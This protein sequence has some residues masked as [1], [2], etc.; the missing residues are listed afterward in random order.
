MAYYE[1]KAYWVVPRGLS[2][3]GFWARP[4][5]S[6]VNHPYDVG[7]SV[8][9]ANLDTMGSV[10]LGKVTPPQTK[11]KDNVEKTPEELRAE[12][13]SKLLGAQGDRPDRVPD[14]RTLEEEPLIA[15]DV[16][17]QR[18][19]PSWHTEGQ[20]NRAFFGMYSDGSLVL[21]SS[22]ILSMVFAS[23][24]GSFNLRAEELN[25]EVLPGF[26]FSV[27][28]KD[29]GQQKMPGESGANYNAGTTESDREDKKLNLTLEVESDPDTGPDL[30]LE[31]GQCSS[32]KDW[33]NGQSKRTKD[34]KLENGFKV[35]LGSIADLEVDLPNKELRI[36]MA[37]PFTTSS[38]F[39]LRMNPDE[40]VLM[41]GSQFISFNDKGIFLKGNII[42]IAGPWTMWG[43]QDLESFKQDAMP[44]TRANGTPFLSTV[45][46]WKDDPKYPGIKFTKSAFF[47]SQEEP[48]VL[49]SF[50]TDV[51]ARDMKDLAAHMHNYTWTTVPGTASTTPAIAPPTAIGDWG[52]SAKMAADKEGTSYL[53]EISKIMI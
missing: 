36:T 5:D 37:V 34:K 47:G 10:I 2:S 51:Y 21:D 27:A 14:Y 18:T 8:L 4:L 6:G 45:A 44:D 24:D 1:K 23:F 46:E 29:M 15:G 30:Y 9:C 41:R 13:T 35:R 49:Q 20:K 22:Y 39:Q 26:R 42:G 19:S 38:P 11:P 7:E 31:G 32:M 50:L 52:E 16:L 12:N 33:K 53:E 40:F 17:I 43:S 28:H 25:L 3:S 48:A